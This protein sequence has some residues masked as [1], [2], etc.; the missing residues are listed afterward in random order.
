LEDATSETKDA[1][2]KEKKH[3]TNL[4]L[5]WISRDDDDLDGR[6]DEISLNGLQ[7]HQSLKYLR[8]TGYSGVR[9]SNWFSTL[10]NLA[11][12]FVYN[13]K[14][15]Q[16]FPPLYQLP[17]LRN[18]YISEML[19]LE[20]MSDRDITDEISASLASLASSSTTFFPSLEWLRL[21]NCPI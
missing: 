20:Y 10:T 1:N 2:L 15:C 17:Y 6:E 12:L 13:C 14:K 5:T 8:V 16:H 11:K 4:E 18:L 19:G 3:L 9:F 21:F 7:P